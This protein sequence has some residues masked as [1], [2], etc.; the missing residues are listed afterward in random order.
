MGNFNGLAN[1]NVELT[2]R[3]NKGDGTLGSGCW[4]CGRRKLEKKHPELCEWGDMPTGMVA[5][6]SRSVPEGIVIQF[7]NNGEPLL[8]PDLGWALSLFKNNIRCLDTNGKLLVE[9]SEEIIGN[10][11]TLTISVIQDDPEGDEQYAIVSDFLRRKLNRKPLLIYRLLGR[12]DQPERWERLPGVI[13]RRILHSPDGSRKYSKPVT[14]PEIGVCIDLLTHLAINRFGEVSVCVRFDPEKKG[15]IG[16]LR[17]QSL[18][19]IWNGDVRK[20]YI[21][22]HL[23][24]HRDTM[25]LCGGCDYWGIA[26]S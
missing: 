13:A 4:M 16:D 2:S 7:H 9:R 20:H 14:V 22:T 21:T 5:E 6:I 10:M 19:K 15:V 1:I 26:T 3:C 12:V 18:D 23:E 17:Y 25:F 11:E 24:G 8:Y